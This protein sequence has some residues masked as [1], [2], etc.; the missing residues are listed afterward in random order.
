VIVGSCG[1]YKITE[2]RGDDGFL[3]PSIVLFVLD[4]KA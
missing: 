4:I 2:P 3:I 1:A